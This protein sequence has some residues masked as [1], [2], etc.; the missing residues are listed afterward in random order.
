MHGLIGLDD[1]K[2]LIDMRVSESS[3]V[4]SFCYNRY[5]RQFGLN[6]ML[7]GMSVFLHKCA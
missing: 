3:Q 6:V 4:V 7:F 1:R 2:G 5:L